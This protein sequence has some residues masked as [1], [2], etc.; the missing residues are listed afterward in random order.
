MREACGQLKSVHLTVLRRDRSRMYCR[1]GPC[2]MYIVGGCT[3]E[4]QVGCWD[5]SWEAE[6]NKDKS[7][8]SERKGS[9]DESC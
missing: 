7:C 3:D 5:E 6:G 8:N 4:E 2:R 9:K 1:S